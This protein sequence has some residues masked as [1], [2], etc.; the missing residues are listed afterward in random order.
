MAD[1][2]SLLH[3][4][5]VCSTLFF[6]TTLILMALPQAR[7]RSI[8]REMGKWGFACLL[9]L[10]V[11]SPLD[12][13]PDVLFPVGFIDD[14]LYLFGAYKS[15]KSAVGEHKKRDLIDELEMA[16]MEKSAKSMKTGRSQAG[17]G[18][19]VE[20]AIGGGSEANGSRI[21]NLN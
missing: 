6:I 9:L 3:T 19:P 8:G 5:V 15:I 21:G 13:V 2:F 12:P 11:P 10:M 7:L 18:A 4:I 20:V 1:F 16:G 14:A 17:A